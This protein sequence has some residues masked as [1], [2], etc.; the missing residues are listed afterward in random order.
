MDALIA[1]I[2]LFAPVIAYVVRRRDY[3]IPTILTLLLGMW[4]GASVLG[5]TLSMLFGKKYGWVGIA[6]VWIY[7]MYAAFRKK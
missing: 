1:L 3:T 5:L 6:F 7:G 4:I 2:I